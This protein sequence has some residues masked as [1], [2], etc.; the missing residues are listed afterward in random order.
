MQTKEC[1]RN[2]DWYQREKDERDHVAGKH[3]GEQ[4]D[5]QRQHPGQMAD[6]FNRQHQPRQ[7]PYGSEKMFQISHPRVLESLG[8]IVNECTDCTT[9]RTCCNCMRLLSAVH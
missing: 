1:N 7:P 4:T 6:E 8:L 3:V 9:E 5:S 2:A